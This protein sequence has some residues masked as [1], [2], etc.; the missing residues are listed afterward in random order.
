MRILRRELEGR[1]PLIGFA[2]A[3]LTLA[4][5]LVE[6]K[7]SKNFDQIKRL[8]F[9]APREAHALLDKGLLKA[10]NFR[11]ND[12]KLAYAYVLTPQGLR[13]KVALT[14]DFLARKEREFQLLQQTIHQL[15]AEIEDLPS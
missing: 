10:R 14:R 13:Q 12:H 1:V 11:R 15:R 9:G 5:Y 8:L 3:P 4:V 7:G 6:G 2:A